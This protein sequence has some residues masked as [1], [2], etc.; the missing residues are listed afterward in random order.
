M[1]LNNIFTIALFL[2]VST[3]MYG[4][5]TFRDNFTFNNYGNNNGSSNFSGNWDEDNDDNSSSGGRIRIANNGFFNSQLRF[6]NLDNARIS[7]DLDLSGASSVILTLDYERTN[8]NE[9]IAVQLWNGS[10]YN[11]AGFLNGSGSFNYTLNANEISSNSSIRFVTASG[12]WSNNETIFVDNVL[13]TATFPTRVIIE[14]VTVNEDAGTATFTA[15]VT[16]T[17]ALGPFTV[18]YQ[19][20]NN[21]ATAGAD[22]TATSGTMT[23]TGTV[24]NTATFDVPILDDGLL[25]GAE[26]FRIE[27]SNSSNNNVV[28]SDTAT[29]TIADDEGIILT[30][31]LT[32]TQC[33][34]VFLDPGGLGN[35]ANNLNEVH[36]LCPEPG[37]DYIAVNFTSFDMEEGDDFLYV[38]DGSSTAATLIGVYDNENIPSYISGSTA[39]GG[40]LTFRFTSDGNGSN[41]GFQADIGCHV[42]GPEIIITDISFDEDVGN[43]VFTVESTRAP[44]GINTIFGFFETDFTVDYTTVDGTALAG[45]DYTAVSGTLT[46]NGEVGDIRTIS[47]PIANDGVPEFDENFTIM[48]TGANAPNDGDVNFSDTGTGTINSQILANVPLNL[49][50]QFD[51]KYD[52]VSTGGTM[53]TQR[54]TGNPC[55]IQTTSSNQLVSDIPATGTIRAAYLYWAHSSFTRDEQVTFEGQTVNAGFV[56]Q[57]TNT[58]RN[59]FGYVSDVTALVQGVPNINTNTFDF[60]G[61]TID[62]NNPYCNTQTV[63]GG[64]SLIVYYEEPSLPAVN[65]NVY[66]GFDGLSNNAPGTPF[67]LDNFFAIAGS[68]AKATFLSWE[69]DDTLGSSGANPERLTI[70]NQANTTFTLTGDGGQTGNNAYNGTIYDNTTTPTAYNQINTY[71]VDL[72]TYDISTFISPGDSQVTAT[73]NVGQD[74]VINMAVVMKVPSNLITGTVFED[75]NYPGGA[76][77][78][79]VTSGGLG[80]SGAIVELF[81]SNGTFLE[82]KTT[83]INGDYSFAGM[84][85]GDYLIKVVNSS[86]RSNRAGGLNCTDCFPVQT[87]RSFGD[88]ATITEVTTEVG[89]ADP[90]ATIDAAL[91]VLNNAQ[92]VSSVTVAS[93]GVT[94]ID[95]GFNFNTIVNTN[96]DGQGSLEQFI[97]NSNN[98]DEVILDVESN[99]IFDPAAGEDISIFMIPPTA[100]P[101]GRTA[102]ANYN[103]AGYF[104]IF[105]DISN[106]LSDVTGNTTIIDGRT[107]RA[108]SGNTNAGTYGSGGTGVGVANTTLPTYDGP[109]IQIHRDN[110]DVINLDGTNVELRYTSV[111]ADNNAAVKV[112]GGSA[113]LM[114]NLLGVN[115]LGS[116]AGNVDY[117]VEQTGGEAII[118]SNYI[119]GNRE[120]GIFINGGSS[121]LIELN[122]VDANGSDACA[123]N[124]LIEDGSSITLQN[125]L[126]ENAASVGI[127]VDRVNGVTI[128][129]NSIGF[130]G[131]NG[132]NCSGNYEGMG[133]KIDGES[134][135]ISQNR[136]YSN[137]SAGIV[138]T[139]GSMNTMT[140]NSIYA[141]GTVVPSLGID[142]EMDGVTLNDNADGDSGPNDLENFPIISGAYLAGT[143]LV[144]AGWASP[145]TT[146][147]VFFT[148]VNEG[149]ATL[150]DNQLG[151]TQDY[152]EGQVFIGTAVE[153]SASDQDNSSS[154]YTDDDGNTDNTNKFKFVFPL[155]PG[156]A[157]GDL[158]TTTGTRS[159]STSEFSPEVVIKAY[160]V[161]TNSRIT[162]RVKTN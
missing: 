43:A 49:F 10:N 73:V 33:S 9:A 97:V 21:S 22:Y 111:Y 133:I 11:T 45:S 58:N 102:D 36:T 48:F 31:G 7:R 29:G 41:A 66:Q 80:V 137:G 120:S 69:G 136:I 141:N 46:F 39:G 38:Y 131:Q 108:Y 17:N 34:G 126:I 98:I 148:D 37:F 74:Y 20:V 154:L 65:I 152:G 18:D 61:L 161:I 40:C 14:D 159:N 56:Y 71:G 149:T 59:F 106:P 24:G 129:N 135:V 94:D 115:A 150:G 83:D 128:S 55:A 54:N 118:S 157:I 47:V 104:D 143:N 139:D 132:G 2:L 90:S 57:T 62:T 156:T 87:F 121:S 16:G 105:L 27:M 130:S 92:S 85:D 81:R 60:S 19:T 145:G 96:V 116:T 93:N 5:E 15:T 67:T 147:E 70:T 89:G 75:V 107:Q 100:D 77:R 51:G 44:H 109:E 84:E 117:G 79:Q 142:L 4:Q 30:D 3:I 91:G 160:T 113:T 25:E 8:G 72:D 144:V 68:G 114:G 140:Q 82:R 12:G 86:V 123:D 125:N 26:T 42:D 1:S 112:L 158:V 127:E 95:F 32:S 110:G 23:F 63:L 119:S 64:W 122:H 28:I 13:F 101:L 99:G 151:L 76:G 138:V 134:T 88:A 35:Y 53:R 52:Y 162:Y 50:R 155:P 153:G 6:R 146:V 78:N 103:A 124:I